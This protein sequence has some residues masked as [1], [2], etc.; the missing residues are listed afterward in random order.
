[1]IERFS[2]VNES[3][4][5]SMETSSIKKEPFIMEDEQP[6]TQP[7]L[8]QKLALSQGAPFSRPSYQSGSSNSQL[9]KSE[10]ETSE[11]VSRSSALSSQ[12]LSLYIPQRSSD[13]S[14]DDDK[15]AMTPSRSQ[16]N[17]KS[18]GICKVSPFKR[19]KDGLEMYH[20]RAVLQKYKARDF[21]DL[22]AAR[23][24]LVKELNEQNFDRPFI[25]HE[26]ETKIVIKCE[27]CSFFKVYWRKKDNGTGFEFQKI[28]S[29]KHCPI[30]HGPKARDAKKA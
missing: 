6:P 27:V 15:E 28:E 2:S 29:A 8:S 7:I 24:T 13:S 25:A 19:A 14:S 16:F 10:L 30:R 22:Q 5:L 23:D 18:K 3:S 17:P 21:N 26:T 4:D 9:I 11:R 12:Q 20:D 1:M